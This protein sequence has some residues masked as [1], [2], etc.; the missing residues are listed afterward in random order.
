[1]NNV[2]DFTLLRIQHELDKYQKTKT[3]PHDLLEGAYSIDDIR[4]YYYHLLPKKYQKIA[5]RLIK[6]YQQNMT[7]DLCNIKK[8]LRKEYESV[9]SN[10]ST[11]QS[12]FKF[13][14]VL[15]KYRPNINPIKAL[16]YELRTVTRS[17]N[18]DSEYHQ[19]L[20]GIINDR[21][22]NNQIIDALLKDIKRL[23]RIVS[24]YYL[25][26]TQF[27][28]EIP[29]ELFHARQMIKDFRHYIA[30]FATAKDWDPEQ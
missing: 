20:L 1:M 27:T 24:R 12:L 16:F 23:E 19:W 13:P 11:E 28:K 4:R 2:F 18:Y 21:E 10:L 25:P 9:I 15:S 22:F 6:D 17:Y 7:Q 14:T 30:V 26:L 3:L 29:L 5:D 8:S